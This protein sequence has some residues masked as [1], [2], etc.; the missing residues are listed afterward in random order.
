[1]YREVGDIVVWCRIGLGRNMLLRHGACL[2]GLGINEQTILTE[3]WSTPPKI[4]CPEARH[5]CSHE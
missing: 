2:E 1:M 4:G 5:A 3:V